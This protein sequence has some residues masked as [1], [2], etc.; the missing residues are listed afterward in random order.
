PYYY[1]LWTIDYGLTLFFIL[2]LTSSSF[3]QT[4]LRAE[5]FF[6]TDPGIGNATPITLAANTGNLVFTTSIPTSS[7]PQG[8][9]QLALRVKETGGRWSNFE[10][11]GFYITASTSS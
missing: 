9:H 8:F 5:Y 1:R 3:S 4:L 2:L 11:R 6:N 10:M 7:L